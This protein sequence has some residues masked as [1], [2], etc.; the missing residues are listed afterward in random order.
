MYLFY[1]DVLQGGHLT[2]FATKKNVF[3]QFSEVEWF[4]DVIGLQLLVSFK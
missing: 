2:I 3:F 4:C 1:A